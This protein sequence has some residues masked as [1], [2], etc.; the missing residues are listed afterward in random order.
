VCARDISEEFLVDYTGPP[1]AAA[2]SR[3]A[4]V[5]PATIFA[6]TDASR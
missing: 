1:D 3:Y 4:P 5:S 2:A 6:I